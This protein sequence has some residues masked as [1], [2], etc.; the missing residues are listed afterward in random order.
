MSALTRLTTVFVD[1]ADP[2]KLA[3]FYQHATGWQL[4]DS[5][6]DFAALDAGPGRPALGFAR[7][8]DHRAPQWPDGG[9]RLHLDFAVADLDRAVAD[10]LRLGATKPAFQPGAHAWVVL[11]DPEGHPFCLAPADTD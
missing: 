11:L 4:T 5:T 10:L 1:C 8:P 3:A 6:E 7:V 9:R 2:I